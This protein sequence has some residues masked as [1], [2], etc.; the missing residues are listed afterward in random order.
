MFWQELCDIYTHT[1]Q[2]AVS[3]GGGIH[4]TEIH[5][6]EFF[7]STI[8]SNPPSLRPP[9]SGCPSSLNGTTVLYFFLLPVPV[10]LVL[11]YEFNGRLRATRDPLVNIG[12]ITGG[13]LLTPVTHSSKGCS[14]FIPAS[15]LSVRNSGLWWTPEYKPVDCVCVWVCVCV[16]VGLISPVTSWKPCDYF[17]MHPC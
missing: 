6:M 13:R 17:A 16:C 15:R 8:V 5:V 7:Y 12:C 1:C 9:P 11:G 3:V 14:L 2:P 4:W 10:L